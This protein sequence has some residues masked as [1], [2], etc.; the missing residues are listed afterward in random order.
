M[1]K[2]ERASKAIQKGIDFLFEK[3]RD[4]GNF[5]N[6]ITFHSKSFQ[7]AR[8]TESIFSACLI[9]SSL[10]QVGSHNKKVRK[11]K[12]KIKGLLLEQKSEVWSFNYW[13]RSSKNAKETPYPD[14]LDDTFCAL[15]S[16][17]E[18]DKNL[19]S[20]NVVGTA[21]TL[22]T[23]VEKEE[24]GPYQTWMVPVK[25]GGGWD[26]VDLAVNSN[27][28]Y[29][30]SIQGVQLDSLDRLVEDA[31]SDGEFKSQYYATEFSV[32]YFISRFYEGKKKEEMIKFILSKRGINYIWRNPLDTALAC[33]A[34]SNFGYSIRKLEKSVDTILSAGK[35]GAWNAY[36][37]VVEKVES[38]CIFYSGS[39]ALTTS[40]CLEALQKFLDE[41]DKCRPERSVSRNKKEKMRIESVHN[42][43]QRGVQ[44]HFAFFD[45]NFRKRALALSKDIL[46][47]DDGREIILLP[48]FFEQILEKQRKRAS[49]E[50]LIGI[51]SANVFGWLAYTVYDDFYD[52][53][54]LNSDLP[55]AN[56]ALRE[57]INLFKDTKIL[58]S[59]FF[60]T[61][62]KVLDEIDMANAWEI[63][64][65]RINN[66]DAKF[67][68]PRKLPDY[69][70]Y[71]MLVKRSFGHALGPLAVMD[72]YGYHKDCSE[73]KKTVNFFKHYIIARQLNDDMH[74][75]EEDL[76]NGHL[77]SVVVRLLEVWKGKMREGSVN[78]KKDHSRLREVFWHEIVVSICD[79][80]LQHAKKAEKFLKE[81]PIELER[82]DFLE[83][84]IASQRRIAE[85]TLK[86]QR[87]VVEFL[88]GFVK[89][90]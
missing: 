25:S 81:M 63:K 11:I 83:K 69:G 68:I 87:E 47:G 74:D 51:G 13:D 26:D 70:K 60:V 59:G 1:I 28:G 40:F 21:I 35:R 29:F 15:S 41:S 3:Q 19:I 23:L 36:P 78:W 8:Q 34:L 77:S 82:C 42:G 67:K 4:N 37:F 86:E 5:A 46:S 90:S 22:L 56:V 85:K 75:W 50:F 64:N 84:M 10:S 55:I 53:N 89:S 24:G 27:V 33:L 49:E 76:K 44:K 14:D 52:D 7:G 2:K 12:D 38:G 62:K 71:E 88:H 16:L 65:C 57:M 66:L 32:L 30:L 9:L 39:K 18:F 31:V 61:F 43:I 6:F 72:F 17:Y 45:E 20:S 80:V 58:S 73:F 48:S 54:G 79:D